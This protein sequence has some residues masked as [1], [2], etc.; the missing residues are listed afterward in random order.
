MLVTVSSTTWTSRPAKTF[1]K[2]ILMLSS[3]TRWAA[4]SCSSVYMVWK[5]FLSM[6]VMCTSSR[7]FS[8]LASFLAVRT[9]A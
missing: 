3:S 8:R 2:L 4:T 9:P 7:F 1:S 5:G 6:R